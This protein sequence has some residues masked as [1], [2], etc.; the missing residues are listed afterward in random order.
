[1]KILVEFEFRAI[2]TFENDVCDSQNV[3]MVAFTE[4]VQHRPPLHQRMCF[5]V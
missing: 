3:V 1:V 4:E 2:K 5:V